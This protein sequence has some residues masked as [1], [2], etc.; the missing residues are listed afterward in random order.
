MEKRVR[1]LLGTIIAICA[2]GMMVVKYITNGNF[3]SYI[4]PFI[5]LW[6]SVI[7]FFNKPKK[8]N[9]QVELSKKQQYI[10]LS[11]LSITLVSGLVVFFTTL[12]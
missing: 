4:L 2:I 1:I 6:I 3:D 11:A 8:E 7:V 12:F 10:I 5:L 9:K